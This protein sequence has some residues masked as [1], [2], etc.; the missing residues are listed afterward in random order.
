MHSFLSLRRLCAV[1]IGLV[2]LSAARVI[3]QLDPII[4]HE[5][6]ASAPEITKRASPNN[7]AFAHFMVGFTANYT[8]PSWEN[9]KT[10]PY[11]EAM[12]TH[13]K[14]S[15]IGRYRIGEG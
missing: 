15:S 11:H 2:Y 12:L 8:V 7:L 5:A 9:G 6:I 3:P 4:G 10:G 14:M 1:L 13:H